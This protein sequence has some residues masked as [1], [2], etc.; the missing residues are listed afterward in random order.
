[1]DPAHRAAWSPSKMALR[2]AV[3]RSAGPDVLTESSQQ[4]EPVGG[5]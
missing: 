4:G 2:L 1:M 5:Q 3:N